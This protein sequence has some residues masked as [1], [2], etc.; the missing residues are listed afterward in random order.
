MVGHVLM[1]LER[2]M[3]KSFLIRVLLT[4]GLSVARQ[5]ESGMRIPA[6]TQTL[7]PAEYQYLL[8]LLALAHAQTSTMVNLCWRIQDAQEVCV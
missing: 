7:A 8:F 1:V 5:V 4:G 6:L 2:L 3:V